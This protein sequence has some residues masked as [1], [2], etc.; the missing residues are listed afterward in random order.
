M[1]LLCRCASNSL[2]YAS[3]RNLNRELH[4]KFFCE[5]IMMYAWH[6]VFLLGTYYFS[7]QG[8]RLSSQLSAIRASERSTIQDQEGIMF[9]AAILCYSST[10][11][12]TVMDFH[13]YRR[14]LF[15]AVVFN[16]EHVDRTIPRQSP[17]AFYPQWP[18]LDHY[19]PRMSDM[20]NLLPDDCK[21]IFQGCKNDLHVQRLHRK[22]AILAIT[23]SLLSAGGALWLYSHSMLLINT[24]NETIYLPSRN[25]LFVGGLAACIDALAK[26]A[27]WNIRKHLVNSIQQAKQSFSDGMI[28]L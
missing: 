18:S 15:R 12:S 2:P 19:H 20:Q 21:T 7:D 16:T 13:I 25:V 26:S 28:E 9:I 8:G 6:T 1:T 14:V 24:N 23:T 17:M 5:N 4:E 11:V 27:L 3:N 10:L 22:F